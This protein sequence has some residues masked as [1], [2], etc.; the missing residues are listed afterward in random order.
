MLFILIAFSLS[1][2]SYGAQSSLI[3][4]DVD[5]LCT[6][7][8]VD[9][10]E[11]P[12]KF[13]FGANHGLCIDS[14]RFRR[15]ITVKRDIRYWSVANI[16][17]N[18][19]F[20]TAKIPL[21]QIHGLRVG[22]ERFAFGVDHVF[23]EFAFK[24]KIQLY[25]QKDQRPIIGTTHALILS[26]EGVPALGQKY[27]L[28]NGFVGEYVLDHRLLTREKLE[29]DL[30]YSGHAVRFHVVQLDQEQIGRILR[31]GIERSERESFQSIYN[32]ITNNCSTSMISLLDEQIEFK[33]K[34]PDWFQIRKLAA[35]LPIAAPIGTE[36]A[37]AHR[38]LIETH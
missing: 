2:F 35:A 4:E 12:I 36:Q 28:I 9:A 14:C 1:A 19:E 8:G 27:N 20:V 38:G 11:E 26:S 34:D 24:S 31:R 16:L 30:R 21:D 18:G 33:S 25:S 37:L 23:L 15:A 10:F 13:T 7:R 3:V 32:L 22:F 6:T 17:H 29:N 5:C